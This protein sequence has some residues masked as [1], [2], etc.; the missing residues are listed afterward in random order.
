M[1]EV[2]AS[3]RFPELRMENSANSTSA[4]S[5]QDKSREFKKTAGRIQ[6]QAAA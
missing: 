3:R 5:N 2:A 4:G 1:V 6:D